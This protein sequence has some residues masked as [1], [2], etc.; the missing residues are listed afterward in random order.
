M[1]KGRFRVYSH[2]HFVGWTDLEQQDR[3]MG[4]AYGE[5]RPDADYEQISK[6]VWEAN[7]SRDLAIMNALAL[8]V[9]DAGE[10]ALPASD[11]WLLSR[12][13]TRPASSTIVQAPPAVQM[14]SLTSRRARP[15]PA[16]T[17]SSIARDRRL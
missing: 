15:E 6:F 2:G 12:K 7:D 14:P 8:E 11:R 5:F 3:T 17:A 10:R 1:G 13:R 16:V 4:T 9:R